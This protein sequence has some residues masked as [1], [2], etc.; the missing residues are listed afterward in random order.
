MGVRKTA[1]IFALIL[2]IAP[3]SGAK[4]FWDQSY[5]KWTHA[6]VVTVLNN[7]PWAQ[8][9]VVRVPM[10][11]LN[12]GIN[13]EREW[14]LNVLVRF[15]SAL[16]IRQSY[17]RMAELMNNY[18]EMAPDQKQAFAARFSR[19]LKIDVSNRVIVAAEVAS[20]VAETDRDLKRFF[21]TASA[22]T[23]KQ[24]VYLITPN[25]GRLQITEYYPPSNDG[26]GAKFIFPRQVNGKAIVDPGDKQITLELYVP[27]VNQK[28]RID[29]K[30]SEMSYNGE[31]S[32]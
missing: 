13:G 17:V 27:P 32:Y 3:L 21:A 25:Q 16:P 28:V 15:F 7:S 10:E 24:D 23:L 2:F 12:S 9:Q 22:E 19:P 11:G 5:E 18:D 20:N 31:L 8:S 1:L 30:V 6:Q 14:T 26:T 4:D 29:F